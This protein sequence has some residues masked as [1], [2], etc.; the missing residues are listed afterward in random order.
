MGFKKQKS[1]PSE[2]VAAARGN[3]THH[4]VSDLQKSVSW[5]NIEGPKLSLDMKKLLQLIKGDLQF[6]TL[7]VFL[8]LIIFA[9]DNV[10]VYNC[11]I[12][13]PHIL[14][15]ISGGAPVQDGVA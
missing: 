7:I 5:N 9:C 12:L 3:R 10:I 6:L 13:I 8:L 14:S 11:I 4:V 15:S 1:L 2:G